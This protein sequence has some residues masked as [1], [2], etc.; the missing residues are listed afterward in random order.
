MIRVDPRSRVLE[1]E[2]DAFALVQRAHV[3]AELIADHARQRD[4]LRSDHVHV[5]SA[6]AE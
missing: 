6:S 3:C 5:D 4:L 1:M 2:R